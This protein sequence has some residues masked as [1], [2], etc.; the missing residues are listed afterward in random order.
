[1]VGLPGLRFRAGQSINCR[2]HRPWEGETSIVG[3]PGLRFRA[4]RAG[5]RVCVWPQ[6]ESGGEKRFQSNED[7]Q[8]P[9]EYCGGKNFV[10]VSSL[11]MSEAYLTSLLPF[12]SMTMIN[13]DDVLDT[14]LKKR[15]EELDELEEV[16]EV[17]DLCGKP[18]LL[19][20]G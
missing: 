18:V 15:V 7:G 2:D 5:R 12:L 11:W 4:G 19:H 16:D 1:M 8:G 20:V 9:Q 14:E 13:M 10:F 3:L 17:C 6:I